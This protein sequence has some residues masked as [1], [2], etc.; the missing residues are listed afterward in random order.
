MNLDYAHRRSRDADE[1]AAGLHGWEQAYE[2]LSCGRFEGEVEELQLGPVQVFAE[3]ANRCVAQSGWVGSDRVSI[4]ALGGGT[5]PCWFQGRRIEAGQLIGVS[6]Q[7]SFDLMAGADTRILALSVDAVALAA[8]NHTLAG[9]DGE[10]GLPRVPLLVQPT[11]EALRRYQTLLHSVLALVRQPGP[12]CDG[13]EA[14]RLLAL[15]LM[16]AL[17]ACVAGAPEAAPLP[18]SAANRRR[19]VAR[20]RGH[21][22]EHAHEVIAV[23]DLC[24]AIGA[25]RR[26]LQY[27]FEDVLQMSPVSYLRTLRLNRVR[28]ALREQPQVPVGELAAR[29]GFWHASRF[30]A[31]Y[32][33]LFGELPSATRTSHAS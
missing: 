15:S 25:S 13:T 8:L 1:Q 17:L 31:D 5:A 11:P 21:M 27:A 7:V 9:P 18:A 29:W 19:T 30:A 10:P 4:A 22:A 33:T 14:R 23:P 28:R 32:R 26:S 2:Q 3:R 16:D 20:A 12:V 24:R 6:S